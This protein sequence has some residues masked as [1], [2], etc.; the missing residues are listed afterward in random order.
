MNATAV[1]ALLDTGPEIDK[2]TTATA[3]CASR[4]PLIAALEAALPAS[5]ADPHPGCKRRT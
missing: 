2:A 1:S 3:F 4:C 5:A